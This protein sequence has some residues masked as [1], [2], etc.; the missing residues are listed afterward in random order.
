[1]RSQANLARLAGLLLVAGASTL[2]SAGPS[3]RVGTYNVK[4]L[5][6]EALDRV[7][8][9]GRGT[10]E[11]LR[12]AAAVIQRVRP[13]VLLINEID[14]DEARRNP[15]LFQQR[16]LAHPQ[17]EAP[18]IEFPWVYFE[19]SNTGVQSGFDFD[20]N[21][22]VGDPE[23]GWGFGRYPGQYAMAVL[24]RY[25]IRNAEA[26]T[27]RL[28][29]WAAMPGHRMPDGREGRPAWYGDETAAA[30]RLSSKSHW[31]VPIEIPGG[32]LH[33]LASHPTPGVFDGPEDRNGRRNADEIRLWVDYLDEAEWLVDDAG[34][35][36]GLEAA[37]SFVVLGDLNADPGAE[38]VDGG[39]AAIAPL[40]AHPRVRDPAPRS[41]GGAEFDRPYTGDP[42]L[43]TAPWGRLDYALPSRDLVVVGSG[44]FAPAAGEAMSEVAIEASDHRLV[45]VDV[46]WPPRP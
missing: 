37:A 23:D 17:G 41:R 22:E 11:Q 6:R 28:L 45:W 26:R 2:A 34:R 27:F 39:P 19:P 4:E 31:D 25:P 42:S 9:E 20:R 32:I 33:L 40:L 16:Y 38:G 36:G 44:V 46:E 5:G 12:A 18:A 15:L 13:D 24:S 29:R 43:R 1:M 35:R 21:G 8:E 7:D 3:V 10:D 30:M 14:F